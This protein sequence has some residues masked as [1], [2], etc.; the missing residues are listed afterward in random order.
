MK[1]GTHRRLEMLESQKLQL[2]RSLDQVDVIEKLMGEIDGSGWA[3]TRTS[4]LRHDLERLLG[5]TELQRLE[6]KAS[7]SKQGKT[8]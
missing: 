4:S 2:L 8:K 1:Y 3:A 7:W 6:E 5:R